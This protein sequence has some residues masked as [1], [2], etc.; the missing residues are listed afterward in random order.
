MDN[1]TRRKYGT[2][3]DYARI[4]RPGLST[5]EAAELLGV[6]PRTITRHRASLGLSQPR[7][8]EQIRPKTP[9]ELARM[10]AMLDDGAPIREVERTFGTTWRTVTQHFPGRAWTKSQAGQYARLVN[11][12]KGKR[13]RAVNGNQ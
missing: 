8:A 2:A 5:A 4:H 12:H 13:A 6:A 9:E 3:E 7:P 11:S 1:R 10:E